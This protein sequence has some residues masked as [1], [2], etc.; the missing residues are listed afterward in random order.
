M[1]SLSLLAL[2]VWPGLMMCAIILF[3]AGRGTPP[4]NDVSPL[5]FGRKASRSYRICDPRTDSD[6]YAFRHGVA[7]LGRPSL[8]VRLVV[9]ANRHPRLLCFALPV[10]PGCSRATTLGSMMMPGGSP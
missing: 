4:L 2:F 1:M 7:G 8:P 9:P 10:C 3:M 5:P 6:S